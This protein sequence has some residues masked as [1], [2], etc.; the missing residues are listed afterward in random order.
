MEREM[1][2]PGNMLYPLPAVMVSCQRQGWRKTEYYYGSMGRNG[3]Q[4]TGDG[5]NFCP[6]EPVF[7]S[8]YKR[9]G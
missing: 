5:F 3:M 9:D 6:S 8:D 4:L 2:R 7:I 1:W